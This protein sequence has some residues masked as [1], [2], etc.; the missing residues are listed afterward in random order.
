[1]MV[2]STALFEQQRQ[3][4]R[5]VEALESEGFEC[6]EVDAESTRIAGAD[7]L[8]ADDLVRL[9]VASSKAARFTDAIRQGATLVV[10]SGPESRLSRLRDVMARFELYPLD[11]SKTD[12]L[13]FQKPDPQQARSFDPIDE[14]GIHR[15]RAIREGYRRAESDQMIGE[16]DTG[17]A[18]GLSRRAHGQPSQPPPEGQA[19]GSTPG[20]LDRFEQSFRRHYEEH[21]L[22]TELPYGEYARAYHYGVVLAQH[23]GFRDHSWQKVEQFARQGWD[24]QTHGNWEKLREAVRYG[25]QTVRGND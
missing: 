2:Q 10:A 5:V 6:I 22:H 20:M 16:H 8:N 4:H 14:G 21:F 24:S 1:M 17:G 25:W 7:E 23:G 18:T 11:L 19:V 9:G 15:D 3:A 12:H 13:H